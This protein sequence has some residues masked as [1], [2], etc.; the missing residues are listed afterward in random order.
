MKVFD[1]TLAPNN[2]RLTCYLQDQSEEMATAKTR[3]AMLVFPGGGYLMCSDREAEPVALHFLSEGYNAFILRYSVGP[4]TPWERSFEDAES[5]LEYLLDHAEELHI[6]KEKIA[7]IGFSAGGHLAASLATLGKNRPAALVMGYPVITEEWGVMVG[8]PMPAC[9]EK[10]DEKTPP[11][12]LFATSDDGLVPVKNS[13]LFAQALA[14][15]DILF[16]MHIYPHGEHGCSVAKP[17]A[18]NG[19]SQMVNPDATDWLKD[20][21]RFLH[22][23]LGDFTVDGKENNGDF[24]NYDTIDLET[25]LKFIFKNPKARA[26]F[27]TAFPGVLAQ[28]EGNVMAR[29]QA[30]GGLMVYNSEVFSKEAVEKFLALLQE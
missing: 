30:L 1:V 17:F 14:Q 22:H 3:P 4:T 11:T 20:S 6:L 2:A 18:A 28:V 15:K 16:E 24:P 19:R 5:S 26:A 21:V 10:V 23:A 9:Q 27:D 13:L 7:V 25:P 12:F 8:K 29:G